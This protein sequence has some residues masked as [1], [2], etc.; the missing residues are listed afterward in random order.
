MHQVLITNSCQLICKEVKH[1][2][3]CHAA[4]LIVLIFTS[5]SH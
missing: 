4:D 1:R 3:M 5:V 2:D